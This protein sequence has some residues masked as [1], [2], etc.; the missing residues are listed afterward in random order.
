VRTVPRDS[1]VPSGF[2]TDTAAS[3]GRRL[4]RIVIAAIVAAAAVA[5]VFVYSAYRRDIADARGRASAGSTIAATACGPIEY[6]VAGDGPP[7]L[8][9]HGAGGGIDQGMAF[10]APLAA[11]GFRVIAMSRFGY[12]RTPLPADASAAAQADAHA[13]L[14]DALGLE[15]AA[16][17]GAS[18]GAPSSMQFA[19]RH[20][21]RTTALVLMVPATYV[22]R[23][24][25]APPITAPRATQFL[26]D[27]ALRS[28]FLFWAATRVARRTV[29]GAI[30]ATPPDLVDRASAAERA[31]VEYM[32][33]G[34]LP[35]S[36]RRQGL[37]NDAVVTSTLP[38][39]DLERID[40]PTL[41]MSFE[42]DR[43]GTYDSARYT[44]AHVPRA[45]FVGYPSGGHVW[46]GHQRDVESGIASFL[47]Q[48]ANPD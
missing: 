24:G 11:R 18:A 13:C 8:V 15:R 4:T 47:R 42:D 44:A 38:R 37:L 39:Y 1:I 17:I 31:R 45:R 30:L 16:I 33:N 29:I 9:V 27:T 32:L 12:L 14:L 10:G 19:L 23:A 6:A 21:D 41:L 34:I 36:P 7:V 46:V 26:F 25:G 20:P 35:V 5:T 28:D 2:V 22:P 43:F 40:A 48:A 3:R